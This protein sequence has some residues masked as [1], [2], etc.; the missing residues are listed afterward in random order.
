MCCWLP[1]AEV[2]QHQDAES[3]LIITHATKR[4]GRPVFACVRGRNITQID[5]SVVVTV[6]RDITTA[7]IQSG[8]SMCCSQTRG[9]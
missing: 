8:E 2:I 6:R 7:H 4:Q 5:V 3:E 9:A 1:S